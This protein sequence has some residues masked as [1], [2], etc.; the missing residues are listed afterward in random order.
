MD[1][2][3]TSMPLNIPIACRLTSE[4]AVRQRIADARTLF[5]Q[6]QT[7]KELPDGYAFQFSGTAETIGP[8]LDFIVTER[9]CC[10]FFTIE[11]LFAPG[12]GPVWLHLR[13]SEAVK[14]FV[15]QEFMEKSI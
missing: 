9:E 4:T 12:L 8:L 15:Q 5:R 3:T 1:Q 13:G 11:L 10:P 14:R 2:P 7:V 6:A